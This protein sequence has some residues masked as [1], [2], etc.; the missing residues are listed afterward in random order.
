MNKNTSKGANNYLV[1]QKCVVGLF[2]VLKRVD[3]K[4]FQKVY[5]L[6]EVLVFKW[7]KIYAA[8]KEG[9]CFFK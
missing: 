1:L 9:G 3:F 2:E 5:L 8:W 7:I 4:M 6:K